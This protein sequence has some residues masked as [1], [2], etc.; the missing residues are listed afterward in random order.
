LDIEWLSGRDL[1]SLF[2]RISGVIER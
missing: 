2:H 1:R